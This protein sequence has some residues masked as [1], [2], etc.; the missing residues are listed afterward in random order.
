[1]AFRESRNKKK[2]F[3][4]DPRIPQQIETLPDFVSAKTIL[5]TQGA[6]G[7]IRWINQQKMFY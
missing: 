7:V 6:D 2:P 4:N 5:D 3:Y 1:M